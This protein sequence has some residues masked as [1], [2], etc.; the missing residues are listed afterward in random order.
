MFR[1]IPEQLLSS[2]AFSF[3][4]LRPKLRIIAGLALLAM[5]SACTQST[6]QRQI[7][8]L[9]GVSTGVYSDPTANAA[10][11]AAAY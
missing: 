5:V 4:C 9:P 2:R 7:S 6:S 1:L 10:A 8:Q 11:L 3:G